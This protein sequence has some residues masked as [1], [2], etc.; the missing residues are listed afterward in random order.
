MKYHNYNGG[1]PYIQ[2][3]QNELEG[4]AITLQPAIEKAA[5]SLYK[6]DPKLMEY[7]LTN[8]CNSHTD[9]VV[10]RWID[11]GEHLIT[12]YNDG[13]V[14]DENGKQKGVGYPESWLREI[15]KSQ[16]EKFKLKELE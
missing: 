1:T 4:I 8:Y 15:V 6:T 2:I 11:L 13:Y 12:K 5:L 16:P 7:Y 9:N 10:K 3:V 14:K